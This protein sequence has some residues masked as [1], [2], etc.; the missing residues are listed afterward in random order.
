MKVNVLFYFGTN[1]VGRIIKFFEGKGD[2]PTHT[3]IFMFDSLLEAL[4]AGFVKSPVDEYANSRT[5]I[6]SVEVPNIAD[7]EAE[8]KRLLYTPYG[9]SDCVNGGIYDTT[10]VMLPGD[11]EI[12]V[13]CSEAVTRIL[14]AGGVDVLPGVYAD[15]V[16]PADLLKALEVMAA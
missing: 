2:N 7:A 10:G 13:N 15:C 11:G 8:A 14:R 5:K 12:T 6:V 3:G 1:W 4:D 9:W 16:T